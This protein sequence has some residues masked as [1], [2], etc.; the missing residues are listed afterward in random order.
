[1]ATDT[2]ARGMAEGVVSQV[3]ADKQAV[4]EDREVV[5]AAKTEVLNVAES[6]PADY[7]TLSAD[8]SGLKEDLDCLGNTL[9][10]TK[11]VV[12][13]KNWLNKDKLTVGNKRIMPNGSFISSDDEYYTT[14]FIPVNEG[15]VVFFYT[16]QAEKTA[17]F[18]SCCC[19][20]KNKQVVSGGVNT[21]TDKFTVP[22]GVSYVKFSITTGQIV[23]STMVTRDGTM[24][25]EYSRYFEP[26]VETNCSKFDDYI[27]INQGIEKKGL[28]LG[29]DDDGNIVPKE[30]SE[31]RTKI[32]EQISIV[33]S[34]RKE[35]VETQIATVSSVVD[36]SNYGVLPSN[37]GA[38]NRANLQTLL[39]NGGS[40]YINV[41]G[42]YDFDGTL[43]IGSDTELF[44]GKQVYCRKTSDIGGFLLNKGAL[45]KEYDSNIT[46]KGLNLICNSKSGS[47]MNYVVG[48]RGQIAFYYINNLIIDG[49]IC[50]DIPSTTYC[51]HLAKWNNILIQNSIFEGEKDGIHLNCGTD[52]TIRHCSF[53]TNDD[54]IALNAHDYV[55]GVPEYSWIENVLVEDCIDRGNLKGDGRTALILG[56][57]WLDWKSGKSYRH[58][59]TIVATNGYVYRLISSFDLTET[60]STI[61]PTHEDGDV[62]YSDGCTWRFIQK[63]TIYN[64]GCRN[65]VFRNIK[66]EANRTFGFIFNYD[67]DGYSRSYYPGAVAVA[68]ENFVF[69]NIIVKKGVEIV[70]L[71]QLKTPVD[72]IRVIN[73]KL[74]LTT[75][76]KATDKDWNNTNNNQKCKV[77]IK[78]NIINTNYLFEMNKDYDFIISANDNLKLRTINNIISNGTVTYLEND[79]T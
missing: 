30:I 49:F 61:S 79:L 11:T 78:G 72:F 9:G 40:I 57:S 24:L 64:V 39:D 75:L 17:N 21:Y 42:T 41:A 63:N 71:L 60:V 50:K 33:N 1:M 23:S 15:D 62:Q 54:P 55:T 2:I 22:N 29:I 66:I 8:V 10:Y 19:F 46:I 28:Y 27:P 43:Y 4:S 18:R 44:F 36:A 7:S 52:A 74:K 58:S 16:P 68:Q 35:V 31:S 37:S 70:R 48:L 51:M 47:A 14:D 67:N 34:E 13:P 26:Y 77:I 32:I 53:K 45:T 56:G 5:E 65:V 73:S 25:S 3:S 38:T 6:I 12:N 69:D 20:N 59:D 76:I